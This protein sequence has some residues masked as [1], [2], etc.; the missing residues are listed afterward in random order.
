MMMRKTAAVGLFVG[1]GLVA[2]A[3]LVLAQA[4]DMPRGPGGPGGPGA[5]RMGQGPG[6][7]RPGLG[8]LVAGEDV[9]VEVTNTDNGVDLTITTEDP[10]AVEALQ[11]RVEGGV[12][13]LEQI[14]QGARERMGPR[15]G[16]GELPGEFFGLLVAGDLEVTSRGV[17]DGAVVSFT[18]D[19]PE[20]VEALQQNMPQWAAQAQEGGRRWQ[21]MR[22]RWERTREALA[23]IANEEVNIEVAETDD[24]ITVSITSENPE[25]VAQI[26]EKLPEYFEGQQEAAR[27]GAQWGGG[28]FGGPEAGRGPGERPGAPEAQP[29]AGGRRRRGR[30][31]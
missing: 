6:G 28:R 15:R 14:A 25:V 18:S 24:G 11:G 8:M 9:Q 22:A 30:R 23:V 10:E 20:V 27:M 29:E 2:C 26:K 17:D 16:P 31:E 21:E 4:P 19:R 7:F 13:R 5:G 3:G 1:L 12:M